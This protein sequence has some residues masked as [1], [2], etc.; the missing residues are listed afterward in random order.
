MFPVVG[1]EI[2]RVLSQAKFLDRNPDLETVVLAA[3]VM[4]IYITTPPQ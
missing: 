4:A 3:G 2:R 1:L